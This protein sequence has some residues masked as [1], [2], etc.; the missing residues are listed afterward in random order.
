MSCGSGSAG[1]REKYV[2][3]DVQG[4]LFFRAGAKRPDPA[5]SMLSPGSVPVIFQEVVHSIG[6]READCDEQS[7]FRGQIE[8][9]SIRMP[10]SLCVVERL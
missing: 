8:W 2:A 4:E 3:A 9:T 5:P 1:G 10:D 6:T 7:S